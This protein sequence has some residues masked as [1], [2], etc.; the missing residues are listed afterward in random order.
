MAN[1]SG[2]RN[3]GLISFVVATV[4]GFLAIVTVRKTVPGKETP[5]TTSGKAGQCGDGQRENRREAAQAFRTLNVTV[6]DTK[7]KWDLVSVGSAALHALLLPTVL[8]FGTILTCQV[9]EN[10]AFIKQQ[11]LH[12]ERLGTIESLL[13]K[14]IPGSKTRRSALFAMAQLGQVDVAVEFARQDPDSAALLAMASIALSDVQLVA[15]TTGIKH[16]G[17]ATEDGSRIAKDF[18]VDHFASLRR[19]FVRVYDTGTGPQHARWAIVIDPSG[20]I[21]A[22]K[23]SFEGMTPPG[24][25]SRNPNDCN[26]RILTDSRRQPLCGETR[27]DPDVGKIEVIK[28]DQ[29]FS[30]FIRVS[31]GDGASEKGHFVNSERGKIG[32]TVFGVTYNTSSPFASI[33]IGRLEAETDGTILVS[34]DGEGGNPAFILDSSSQIIALAQSL[35]ANV[36]DTVYVDLRPLSGRVAGLWEAAE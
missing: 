14:V 6:S 31:A 28:V 19:A 10:E 12:G 24:A 4:A 18:L 2:D 20:I 5:G 21:V 29:T 22:P 15:G 8:A 26:V 11:E 35:G 34:F 1:R 25:D 36:D 17:I 3:R 33:A 32:K 30:N 23:K 7:D 16:D 27:W 9:K 13:D